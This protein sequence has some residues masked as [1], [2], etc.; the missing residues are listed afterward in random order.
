MSP[1]RA[2]FIAPISAPEKIERLP[3]TS[4]SR[5]STI[6]TSGSARP[7]T[8]WF[9]SRS[10]SRLT[11]LTPGMTFIYVAIDGVALPSSSTPPW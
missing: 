3:L 2:S 6:C 11:G 4:S 1:L 8:R 5:M 10:V 7:L 9:I